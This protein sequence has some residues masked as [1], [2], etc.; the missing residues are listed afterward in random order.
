MVEPSEAAPALPSVTAEGV[1][2][3]QSWATADTIDSGMEIFAPCP[4]PLTAID[5]DLILMVVHPFFSLVD[6]LLKRERNATKW[7]TQYVQQVP[8]GA[9][10]V[11]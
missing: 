3:V 5:R 1:R 8:H 11:S 9:E 2:R 7:S 4:I 6:I 10:G